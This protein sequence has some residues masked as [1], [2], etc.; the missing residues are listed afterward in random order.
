M[1]YATRQ[2]M[3]DRYSEDELI[4]LTDKTRA[5]M[6][7]N[8]VLDL[9]LT[10]ADD[11]ITPYLAAR[12]VV[13]LAS[14]P[15]SIIR[16]ACTI[17]RYRLYDQAATERVAQDYKDAIKFLQGIASGALDIGLNTAAAPVPTS[18][19]ATATAKPAVFD[20]STLNGF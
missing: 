7:D 17:A 20:E 4:Q 5:G 11:E 8:S 19:P 10:D 3:I 9:A 14:V 16:I 18:G 13:P 12:Y 6:I 15:K 2:N 1:S